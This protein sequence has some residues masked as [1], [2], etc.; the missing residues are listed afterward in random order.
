M[1]IRDKIF[2]IIHDRICPH[3]CNGDEVFEESNK[4]TDAILAIEVEGRTTWDEQCPHFDKWLENDMLCDIENP[5]CTSKYTDHCH[6]E[7]PATIADLTGE[8]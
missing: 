4:L 3:N 7:R 2:R 6:S 5:E 1:S 8:Q